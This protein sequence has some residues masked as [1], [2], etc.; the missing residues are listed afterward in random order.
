MQPA[1]YTFELPEALIAQVPL[2]ERAASRLLHLTPAGELEDLQFKDFSQCPSRRHCWA[3]VAVR[4]AQLPSL[5]PL[6]IPNLRKRSL[7][8]VHDHALKIAKLIELAKPS[9]AH[10]HPI[11][12]RLFLLAPATQRPSQHFAFYSSFPD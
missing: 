7:D 1:D 2:P 8:S 5:R 12:L 10:N 3:M 4:A 6:D 11:R 9:T